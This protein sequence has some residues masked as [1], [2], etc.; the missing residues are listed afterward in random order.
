VTRRKLPGGIQRTRVNL[1][2]RPMLLK[3]AVLTPG[4]LVGGEDVFAGVPSFVA[5]IGEIRNGNERRTPPRRRSFTI[6]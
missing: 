1:S 5:L 3:G 6:S 2:T 4:P